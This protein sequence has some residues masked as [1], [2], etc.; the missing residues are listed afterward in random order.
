[1]TVVHLLYSSILVI[2]ILTTVAHVA[3]LMFVVILGVLSYRQ[4]RL[5]RQQ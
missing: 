1:M 2:V 5:I 3:I 4:W